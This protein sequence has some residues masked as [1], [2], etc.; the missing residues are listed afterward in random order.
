[1]EKIFSKQLI[2]EA[3]V[4]HVFFIVEHPDGPQEVMRWSKNQLNE[5]SDHYEYVES[6]KGSLPRFI[7]RI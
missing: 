7:K 2:E 1:M 6:E 3:L 4:K 5:I